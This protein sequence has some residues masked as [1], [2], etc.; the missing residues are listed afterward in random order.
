MRARE[1]RHS[2]G[3][4]ALLLEQEVRKLSMTKGHKIFQLDELFPIIES[5]ERD[6]RVLYKLLPSNYPEIA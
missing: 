4:T 3:L 5:R 1:V 6:P 2:M